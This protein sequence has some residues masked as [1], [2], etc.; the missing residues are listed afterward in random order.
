MLSVQ[1][2]LWF[3]LYILSSEDEIIILNRI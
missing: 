1:I 2:N 3:F